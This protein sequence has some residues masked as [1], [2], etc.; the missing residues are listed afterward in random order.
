MCSVSIGFS[1]SWGNPPIFICLEGTMEKALALEMSG[2]TSWKVFAGN[3]SCSCNSLTC[4]EELQEAISSLIFAASRC[5]EL[6]ELQ[7]IRYIF[8]SRY[9]KEFTLRATELRNRCGVNLKIIQKLSTRQPSL[10]SRMKLL[11]EIADENGVSLQLEATSMAA[12]VNKE[13]DN[14]CAKN[15]SASSGVNFGDDR[16]DYPEEMCRV[17]D[18]SLSLNRGKQYK[19]VAEAAQEAFLSAAYAASAARAAVDLSRSSS[20]GPPDDLNHP[21]NKQRKQV[22]DSN[23]EVKSR[24]VNSQKNNSRELEDSVLR[25]EEVYPFDKYSLNSDEEEIC[26]SDQM[27]NIKQVDPRSIAEQNLK[28][29]ENIGEDVAKS[30]TYSLEDKDEKEKRETKLLYYSPKRTATN[31]QA[32]SGKDSKEHISAGMAVKSSQRLNTVNRPVSVRTRR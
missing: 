27:I 21:S 30:E 9:G 22:M 7:E 24:T 18:L 13:E 12:E 3:G 10:E 8:S 32:N 26:Q 16:K 25:H 2:A 15:Q 5:G 11:K 1:S 23:S 6:P 14:R 29:S 4:P 19:D 17:G 31:I 20:G 28:F